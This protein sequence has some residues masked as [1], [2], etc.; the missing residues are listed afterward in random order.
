VT[1]LKSESKPRRRSVE[2]GAIDQNRCLGDRHLLLQ[3]SGKQHCELRRS[4]RKEPNVEKFVRLGIDGGVQPAA[5]VVHLDH[6]LVDR[7]VI[8]CCIA[9]RV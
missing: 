1:H 7:D 6:R 2:T 9:C 3:F 4:G 8:R 5:L